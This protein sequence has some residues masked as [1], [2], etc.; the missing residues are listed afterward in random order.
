MNNYQQFFITYYWIC[1]KIPYK[2][3]IKYNK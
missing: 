1:H 3:V 2:T